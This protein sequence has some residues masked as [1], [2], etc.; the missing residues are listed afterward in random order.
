MDDVSIHI[1][2]GALI[3]SVD[4]IFIFLLPVESPSSITVIGAFS[5][6]ET[7]VDLCWIVNV[8]RWSSMMSILLL[9][10]IVYSTSCVIG[11]VCNPLLMCWDGELL[12]EEIICSISPMKNVCNVLYGYMQC[13]SIYC[14]C[15]AIWIP[16]YTKLILC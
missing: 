2:G 4:S 7:S 3:I 8:D 15:I 6:L 12:H 5:K 9:E 16:E 13:M 14:S 10:T 1:S 11:L